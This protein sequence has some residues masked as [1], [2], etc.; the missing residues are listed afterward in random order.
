MHP[1]VPD[2]QQTPEIC[3]RRPAECS[4]GKRLHEVSKSTVSF[5]ERFLQIALRVVEGL[6]KQSKWLIQLTKIKCLSWKTAQLLK[7]G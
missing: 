7:K 4:S 2:I 1:I 3:P 5:G 6:E